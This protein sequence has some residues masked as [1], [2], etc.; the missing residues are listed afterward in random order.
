MKASTS[1]FKLWSN[2]PVGQSPETIIA[3]ALRRSFPATLAA[4]AAAI[5]IAGSLRADTV[6]FTSSSTDAIVSFDSMDPAGTMTTAANLSLS[7]RPEPL[8]WGPDGKIYIGANGDGGAIAPS[9]VRLNPGTGAL[10]LVYTFDA[11]DV[12][13]G[14]LAFNSTDLLVGRN[15]FFGNTG[16][17][18]RLT[19]VTGGTIAVS[20]YTLDGSLA[21]SPGIVLAVD[22]Q[23]YVSDQTYNFI[24]G[25]ASGAVK[26]FD[27]TGNYVDDV[28]GSGASGNFG[29]AGLA[30][31]GS[32]L[33]SASFMTGDVLKTNL[34]TGVTEL[35][36][37]A[38]APSEVSSLAVLSNG[39]VLAGSSS[40]SGL[41]YH[42]N[43]SGVLTGT[44]NTGFGQIGGIV[45]QPV[46]EPATLALA[47][48]GVAALSCLT[49][50][51]QRRA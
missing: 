37:S 23:L 22:G 13:P 47:V 3:H 40:G 46:P 48:G 1:A 24:S 9:I 16:P 14:S 18:V 15:P 4:A 28:I 51:R 32:T 45:V 12:F 44:I 39:D 35:F 29:P 7:A 36:G 43:S 49:R 10:D 25:V 33:Y 8:A 30:I 26:R 27:A 11:F 6:Y 21:S 41:I 19:N 34:G 20:D 50:R 31:S 42:F 2:A 17:I 38:G 5:L